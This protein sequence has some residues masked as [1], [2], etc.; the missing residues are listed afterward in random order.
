MEKVGIFYGHLQYFEA[1]GHILWLLGNLEVIWCIFHR[2][3]ILRHGI[4]GNPVAD[5]KNWIFFVIGQIPLRVK[6]GAKKGTF[7]T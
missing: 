7:G 3:G 2:F 1:I 5:T 4:S 6:V